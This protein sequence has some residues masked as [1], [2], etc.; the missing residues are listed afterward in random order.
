MDTLD[1]RFER[2]LDL[3]GDAKSKDD[4]MKMLSRM[5]RLGTLLP[6]RISPD[7]PT[8]VGGEYTFGA[9]TDSY[10]EYLVRSPSPL[11]LLLAF[12]FEQ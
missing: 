8:I 3:S 7:S 6:T 2:G 4:G 11:T 12:R 1:K 9:L 5:S 10:Y